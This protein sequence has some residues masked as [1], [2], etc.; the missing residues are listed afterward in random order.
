MTVSGFPWDGQ[1]KN[2]LGNALLGLG[3]RENGTKHLEEAIAAYREALKGVSRFPWTG[4][5]HRTIL[6]LRLQPRRT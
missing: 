5:E 1:T 4:Q 3:K 6:A 2:N